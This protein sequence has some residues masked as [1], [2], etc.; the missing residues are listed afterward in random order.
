MLEEID[1]KKQQPSQCLFVYEWEWRIF[2]YV[3]YAVVPRNNK[4]VGYI[5]ITFCI[6]FCCRKVQMK[7][8]NEWTVHTG[9]NDEIW[10]NLPNRQH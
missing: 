6:F 1:E 10:K 5:I 7:A 4:I 9:K 8:H 2:H 3:F